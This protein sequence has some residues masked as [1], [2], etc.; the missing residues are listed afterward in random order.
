MKSMLLALF[1]LIAGL[2]PSGAGAADLPPQIW[3][4]DPDVYQFKVMESAREVKSAIALVN[5]NIALMAQDRNPL[6]VCHAIGTLSATMVYMANWGLSGPSTQIRKAAVRQAMAW[7]AE[8]NTYCRV[9][10][11]LK[12]YEPQRQLSHPTREVQPLLRMIADI[13]EKI[14]KGLIR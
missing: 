13:A 9:S 12:G 8:V 6:K 10:V 11:N 4:M 2:A 7:M 14:E 3:P 5:H 1:I